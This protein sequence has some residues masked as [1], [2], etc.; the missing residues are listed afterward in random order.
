MTLAIYSCFKT[1]EIIFSQSKLWGI[2][3]K[4]RELVCTC[5]EPYK[6]EAFF[7]LSETIKHFL[8]QLYRNTSLQ[9]GR[10]LPWH[11]IALKAFAQPLFIFIASLCKK[12]EPLL[13]MWTHWSCKRVSD[14]PKA[15][16]SRWLQN[17]LWPLDLLLGLRSAS[18]DLST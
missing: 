4:V 1:P 11:D 16:L 12:Q 17:W 7:S 15:M 6:G 9:T 10:A 13:S 8:S 14:L 5:R 18:L 3:W 2:L